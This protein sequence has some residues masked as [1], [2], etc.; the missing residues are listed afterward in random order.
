MHDQGSLLCNSGNLLLLLIL[1]LLLFFAFAG[2]DTHP[3]D[4]ALV[5][6]KSLR[7]QEYVDCL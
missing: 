6:S 1:L 7:S 2:L 5:H 4:D 3:V